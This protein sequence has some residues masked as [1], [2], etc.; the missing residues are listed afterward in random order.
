[1]VAREIS[2]AVIGGVLT[3]IVIESLGVS[4]RV[5]PIDIAI[6]DNVLVRGA[7]VFLVVSAGIY[8]IL[9]FIINR[10]QKMREKNAPKGYTVTQRPAK[11]IDTAEAERFGVIWKAE[12]GTLRDLPTSGVDDAYV[13][14]LGAYCPHDDAKLRARTVTKWFLF[15]DEAW[16]C[17]E[18]GRTY[19]R[20]TTHY[21][22][23]RRIVKERMERMYDSKQSYRQ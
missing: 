12:Y 2:V 7:I 20:P 1:M 9:R 13:H 8:G 4:E 15:E 22:D 11:V 10:R 18:C 3:A 17:P 21:G 19:S 6:L 16:V 5:S 23:E 14:M